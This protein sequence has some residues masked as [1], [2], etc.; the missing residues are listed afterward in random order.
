MRATTRFFALLTFL[1]G[2]ASAQTSRI[3]ARA[4]QSF[5]T[6]DEGAVV[7]AVFVLRNASADSVALKSSLTL[8][9]GWAN[10]TGLAPKFLAA[11]ATDTWIAG[12]SVPA[13]TAAGRYVIHG[14]VDEGAG[15][16]S[17]S[18]IVVVEPRRAVEILSVAV[19]A[20]TPARGTYEAAFLVRNRGNIESTIDLAGRTSRG[21]R[22]N[23]TPASAV[24]I[25]GAAVRVVVRVSM[26]LPTR[27]T[28]DDVIELEGHIRGVSD[29]TIIASS[30][31]TVVP[32]ARTGSG[33]ESIPATLAVRS[34]DGAAGVA[35][36]TFR[37]AGR[38]NGTHTDVDFLLQ[39][40]TNQNGPVNFGEREEY[41]FAMRSEHFGARIGDQL[42]GWSPLTSSG[43]AGRGAE[44]RGTNGLFQG[45]A[46]AERPRWGQ[47]TR[48]EQGGF[49]G[50]AVDSTLQ[51]SGVAMLRQNDAGSSARVAAINSRA[52]IRGNSFELEGAASDSGTFGVAYRARIT[53]D[54]HRLSYEAGYTKG[55]ADFAGPFGGWLSKGGSLSLQ[56]TR[57][58]TMS[59]NAHVNEWGGRDS[60]SIAAGERHTTTGASL[61]WG[62]GTFIEYG[63]LER[64]RLDV[65]S[66][67]GARQDG[68]RIST[69]Q[70]IGILS[71]TVGAEHGAVTDNVTREK[72]GYTQGS[73][74]LSTSAGKFGSLGV[75]AVVNRGKTLTGLRNGIADVGVNSTL[76]LPYGFEIGVA[77]SARRAVLGVLDSSGAWFSILDARLDKRIGTGSVLGVHVR[78]MESPYTTGTTTGQTRGVY[79]EYRRDLR[80]PVKPAHQ[81]GRA[82]GRI[83]DEDGAPLVGALVRLGQ[84]AAI[85]DGDGRVRFAGLEPS[86]YR[87]SVEP[88]GAAAGAMITGDLTVDLRDN[89]DVVREFKV[90][91]TRGASV[92]ASVRSYNRRAS[93]GAG[94]GE[95]ADA[96]GVQ[97]ML[98]QLAG[99]RDTIYQMSDAAGRVNFGSVAP[100]AYVLSVRGD[101]PEQ[102]KFERSQIQIELRAGEGSD[103]EIRLVPRERSIRMIDAGSVKASRDK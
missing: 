86:A 48:A 69:A 61:S 35:P 18:V 27:S 72:N 46:Y 26:S 14:A 11:R 67:A 81:R 102:M 22:A 59:A 39:A 23:V 13:N 8:P 56:A 50:I 55:S 20:W 17:D 103:T 51:I 99:A 36:V 83:T 44:V 2:S 98:M 42:F 57:K 73:L 95:L 93:V 43:L 3:V 10:V 68:I 94:S 30:R 92:R 60:S 91:A 34:S 54:G 15:V 37:G 71:A 49:A 32:E 88:K 53:R 19:P 76:R 24:L 21:T 84:E 87:V 64:H 70:T 85:S 62:G 74:T 100:G 47:G 79:L 89:A 66:D 6:A 28:T 45:G 75:S 82:T 80:V 90:V 9:K 58:L 33:F 78:S 1:A 4:T 16:S 101:A 25:P 12:I 5:I 38:I 65:A 97:G 29:S 7:T 41:R 96:G 40:P 52:L 63:R 31:T 77:G